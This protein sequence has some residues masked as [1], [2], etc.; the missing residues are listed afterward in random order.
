MIGS[1]TTSS[2]AP[3]VVVDTWNGASWTMRAA[4]L[5]AGIAGADFRAL[6]V[7]PRSVPCSRLAHFLGWWPPEGS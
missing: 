1:A 3:R 4:A 6:Q 5:P 2:D 7:E